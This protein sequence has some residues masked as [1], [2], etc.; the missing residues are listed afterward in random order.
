MRITIKNKISINLPITDE[1]KVYEIA[2]KVL[3]LYSDEE[4]VLLNLP[5]IKKESKEVI[6]STIKALN[7]TEPLKIPRED[8]ES[9]VHKESDGFT[10]AD[11]IDLESLGIK[12]HHPQPPEY[13][14]TGVKDKD[15]IPHYR[16]RY[17]CTSCGTISNHY[18]PEG[19]NSVNCHECNEE[20]EVLSVKEET[21]HETDKFA[22]WYVAGHF[23]PRI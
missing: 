7:K 20:M 23:Q 4:E 17:M 18:I 6:E 13:F 10:I 8:L 5:T 19:A 11:K 22:N 9:I 15:G 3:S 14:Q 2:M 21:G 1:E 12:K 16:C